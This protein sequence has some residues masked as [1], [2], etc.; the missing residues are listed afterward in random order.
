MLK[1][2]IR[3]INKKGLIYIVKDGVSPL[4]FKPWLGD[5]FSFLYDF[6]MQKA[7]FPKNLVEI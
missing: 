1:Q 2:G 5:A 3:V 4:E 6:I 7:I